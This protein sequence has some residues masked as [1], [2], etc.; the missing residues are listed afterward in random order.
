MPPVPADA[1]SIAQLVVNVL[2]LIGG[3]V[4]W[5]MYFDSLKSS[6]VSKD[7]TIQTVEKNL[8]LWRDKANE[9]EKRSP[10]FMERVL[11]DRISVREQEIKSL[12]GDRLTSQ[13]ELDAAV[14]EKS[15]LQNDLSRSRGFRAMLAMDEPG[16]EGDID[17]ASLTGGTGELRVERLGVVGVD[18]GQ[19]MV[20]DPCY[21]D[22]EWQVQPIQGLTA[23]S[24]VQTGRVYKHGEDFQRFDEGA[25]DL[26]GTVQ[27]NIES[28][29]LVKLAIDP[30]R[31]FPYSYRGACNA[32]LTDGF[33]QLQY[34]KGPPGAGVVF[35]TAW[36]DGVYPV[37]GEM[38]DGHIVRVYVNVG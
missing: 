28:G 27:Q 19:L 3:S 31:P 34:R 8:D 23:Y 15:E 9:L 11:S 26:E 14:R 20:T 5:K 25:D 17:L 6:I 30:E 12:S 35:A 10:E 38:I 36:G 32:T 7:A 29:R 24:D 37:Y 22:S 2:A 33:G 16:G 13:A 21:V 1:W 4:V 18:S